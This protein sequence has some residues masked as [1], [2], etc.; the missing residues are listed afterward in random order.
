LGGLVSRSQ[1]RS[2]EVGVGCEA[3]EV[4]DNNVIKQ[5]VL[6]LNTASNL[7][8]SETNRLQ[9]TAQ[10]RDITTTKHRISWMVA[11]EDSIRPDSK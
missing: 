7:T 10:H 3:V 5:F 6:L 11:T 9:E 1:S 2:L 8:T 4:V